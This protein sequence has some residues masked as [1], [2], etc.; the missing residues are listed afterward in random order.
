MQ[1]QTTFCG[2]YSYSI[3]GDTTVNGNIYHKITQSG[4]SFQVGANHFCNIASPNTFYSAYAGS[5]RQDSIQRKVYFLPPASMAD[6]LLYDFTLNIGDTLKT[7][8]TQVCPFSPIVVTNIDSVLIG[9]QYRKRWIVNESACISN[10][11]IIEGIGSTFGP[12][13][14]M[15]N[16]GE[17]GEPTGKLYCFSQNNQTLYPYYSASSGCNQ[18]TGIVNHTQSEN[19]FISP[20]PTSNQFLI[21]TNTTDKLNIGL[22]DINGR[23]MFSADVLDK[24]T[25]NVTGLNEGVYTLIIRTSDRM[26]NKKLVIIR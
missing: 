15:T 18:V 20:N 14:W 3:T 19:I 25:I 12:F 5:I 22:Y 23:G 13:E 16:L 2:I 6:S 9:T 7:Y 26:L 11:E 4:R 1:S 17:D 10:G 24:S 21:E 8:I